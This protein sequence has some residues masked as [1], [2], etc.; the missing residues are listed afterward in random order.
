MIRNYLPQ[1]KITTITSCPSKSI[2]TNPFTILYLPKRAEKSISHEEQ[3]VLA[4]KIKNLS[5][6]KL[7]VF[8]NKF[9]EICPYAFSEIDEDNAKM[10]I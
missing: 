5:V 1:I 4:S 2:A 3:E 7:E 6:K 8:I 10:E 9:K